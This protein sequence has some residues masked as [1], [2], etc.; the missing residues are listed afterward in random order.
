MKRVS[1]KRVVYLLK[2]AA[3]P[4]AE[5]VLAMIGRDDEE[6]LLTDEEGD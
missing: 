5:Q 4:N 3:L 1:K 6:V 2:R